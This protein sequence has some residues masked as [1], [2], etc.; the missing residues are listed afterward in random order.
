[1]VERPEAESDGTLSEVNCLCQEDDSE[2]PEATQAVTAAA[3]PRANVGY[4]P[5]GAQN[6]FLI[7]AGLALLTVLPASRLPSYRPGEILEG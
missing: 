3:C 1:M 6:R 5:A 4:A 2:D 7:M